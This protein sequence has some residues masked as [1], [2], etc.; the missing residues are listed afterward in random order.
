MQMHFTGK[1][2]TKAIEKVVS[3]IAENLKISKRIFNGLTYVIGEPLPY[4]KIIDKI[5]LLT[6]NLTENQVVDCAKA[7]MTTDTYPKLRFK[8][9]K[10]DKNFISILGIA[11]GSGMIAPNMATMLSFIITD[12]KISYAILQKLHLI[13][14]I[15][16]LIL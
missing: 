11:K 10:L 6:Q 2:G 5:P 14:Q 9:F 12:I 16:P 1:E 8:K 4:K 3:E 15:R 7:I 13:Y